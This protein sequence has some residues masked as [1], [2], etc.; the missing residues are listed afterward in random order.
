[1]W[2]FQDYIA[3]ELRNGQPVFKF[4][5]G[6]GVAEIV[7]PWDITDNQWYRITAER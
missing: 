7:H 4:E 1:M 2:I 5:L 3:L 6:S